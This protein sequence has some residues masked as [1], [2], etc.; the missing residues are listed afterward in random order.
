MKKST[1]GGART[2]KPKPEAIR[3]NG[4]TVV[5]AAGAKQAAASIGCM[6]TRGTQAGQGNVREMLEYIGAGEC[7]VQMTSIDEPERMLDVANKIAALTHDDRAV[8]EALQATAQ[9]LKFAA[10]LRKETY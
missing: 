10:Q 9:A 2:A 4:K 6:Q 8:V 1:Y 5:N 3:V 7:L